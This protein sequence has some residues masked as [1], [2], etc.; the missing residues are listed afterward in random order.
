MMLRT[1]RADLHMHTCLSPCADIDMTPRSIVQE[2]LAADL[3]MIAVCDHNSAENAAATIRAAAGTGLTVLPGM[4]DQFTHAC[5]G[6]NGELLQGCVRLVA[7]I[8]R[9]GLGISAYQV[10]L[11]R[12]L[13]NVWPCLEGDQRGWRIE[14]K[15]L[16][17]VHSG[18][19]CGL[20]LAAGVKYGFDRQ[21][22]QHAAR[23][24][25]H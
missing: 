17:A 25:C 21:S 6:A 9:D 12:P 13:D 8:E 2:A 18:G 15:H 3:D 5:V 14:V 22:T 20:A 19:Q 24:S 4:P 10:E 23:G 11:N 1:Y 7:D 16:K